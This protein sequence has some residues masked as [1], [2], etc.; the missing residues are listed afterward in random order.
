RLLA[1][2][3]INGEETFAFDPAS[4]L[5]DPQAPRR[6]NQYVPNKL[7]DNLLRDYVG[8]HYSYDERGNSRSVCT[9]A[10]NPRSLGIC[11][12]A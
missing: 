1:A 6:P 5:L 3:T 2:Q 12:T 7:L 8:T 11:T 10:K 4:N 9:T